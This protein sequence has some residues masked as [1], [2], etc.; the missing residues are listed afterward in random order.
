VS[1]IVSFS[2]GGSWSVGRRGWNKL[3][4][5]AVAKLIEAGHADLEREVYDYG[6]RFELDPE[7][8]RI[9]IAEALLAAAREVQVESGAAEGWNPE[10]Q[11][12]YFGDLVER[13][14]RELGEA[15]A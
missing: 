9:P 5:R 14:E 4:E 10:T 3:Q 7:N 6:V 1:G 15:G 13:L 8:V 12:P 11:G 2:D